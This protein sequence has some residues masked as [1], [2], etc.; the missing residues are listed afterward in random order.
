MQDFIIIIIII[1]FGTRT[2]EKGRQ[3]NCVFLVSLQNFTRMKKE[4]K[5]HG[6]GGIR[7]HA[8]EETGA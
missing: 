2:K 6:S 1:V 4:Q 7:T 3:N 8:S 5:K